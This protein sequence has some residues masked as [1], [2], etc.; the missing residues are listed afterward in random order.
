[1]DMSNVVRDKILRVGLSEHDVSFEEIPR[2]WIS[3]FIGGK[4]LAAAYYNREISHDVCPLESKNKL[5][6]FWGPL[7]GIAGGMSRHLWATKSPLTNS[8]LDS[9]AGGKFPSFLAYGLPECLGIIFENFSEDLTYLEIT[10]GGVELRDATDLEMATVEE[11]E[12]YFEPEYY[13]AC[14]GP[15]GENLVKFA[16]IASDGGEHFAGRGGAGAVMGSKNLKAVAVKSEEPEFSEEI[17]TYRLQDIGQM[18]N[19]TET[20]N[21][22]AQTGTAFTI[23]YTNEGGLLPSYGYTKGTFDGIDNINYHAMSEASTGRKACHAC[24]LACGWS[25]KPEGEYDVET[26]WGPEY[27][28]ICLLGSNL[29][30]DDLSA[31]AY[32]TELCDNYGIDSIEMGNIIGFIMR[33]SQE[34]D[35]DYVAEFGDPHVAEEL[36]EKTVKKEGIGKTLS[37]GL[38][39]AS[40]RLSKKDKAASVK[41]LALPAYDPRGRKAMILTYVTGDRGGCHRRPNLAVLGMKDYFL[42]K[43]GFLELTEQPGKLAGKAIEKQNHLSLV[44]S[45]SACDFVSS[46]YEEDWGEEWL[47]K[48]G[49][50]VTE[51]ELEKAGERIWNLIRMNNAQF[52]TPEELAAEFPETLKEPLKSPGPKE[53]VKIGE[54]EIISLISAYYKEREWDDRGIP[55]KETLKRLELEGFEIKQDK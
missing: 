55:T 28:S 46:I 29:G 39:K 20:A 43:A 41:G 44:W 52:R 2:D 11:V 19:K 24:S 36:I 6:L 42:E 17:K 27:E 8:W 38:E 12:E 5:M 34:G 40:Y 22:M 14:I 26:N 4:G 13:H 1:M 21:A 47:N 32:L 33:L 49:Y 54:E 50:D 51:E 48:I 25:V 7:T 30:I 15:G 23:D 18:R 3:K 35:I 31:V 45:L 10:E 16:N 37:E 53:G 9:Y